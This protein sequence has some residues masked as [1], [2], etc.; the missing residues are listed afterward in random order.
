M[1]TYL[2]TYLLREKN[3]N[4]DRKEKLEQFLNEMLLVCKV[5]FEDLKQVLQNA[6]TY[7]FGKKKSP[8]QLV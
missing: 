2:L 5:D 1:K 4:D 3:M 8:K 6:A 7:V